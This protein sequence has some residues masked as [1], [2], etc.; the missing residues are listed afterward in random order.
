MA[1]MHE[2]I[3]DL[4]LRKQMRA[5]GGMA[6]SAT[7]SVRCGLTP[8]MYVDRNLWASLAATMFDTL[9]HEETADAAE[10]N[11]APYRR[12]VPR[13]SRFSFHLPGYTQ[14]YP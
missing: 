1:L 3:G 8:G 10:I 9:A 7:R 11:A 14:D 2:R 6:V 4:R 13:V 5:A 12:W